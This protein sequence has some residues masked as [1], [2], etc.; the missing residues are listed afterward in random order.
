M[1]VSTKFRLRHHLTADADCHLSGLTYA[2]ELT[3]TLSVLATTFM[4]WEN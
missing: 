2:V 1:I 3:P 4:T